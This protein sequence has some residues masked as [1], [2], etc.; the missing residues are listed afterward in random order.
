MVAKHSVI[1][2]IFN[3]RINVELNIETL[4][5]KKAKSDY[6]TYEKSKTATYTFYCIG[7]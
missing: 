4:S 3:I 7:I 5:Y 1:A 2:C 6:R